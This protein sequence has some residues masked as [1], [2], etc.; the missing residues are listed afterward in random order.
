MGGIIRGIASI[1]VLVQLFGP[2]EGFRA[3][4]LLGIKNR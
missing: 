2:S 3:L 1:A 4:G